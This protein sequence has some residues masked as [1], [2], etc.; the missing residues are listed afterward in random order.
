MSDQCRRG[1]SDMPSPLETMPPAKGEAWRKHEENEARKKFA[2][3][4][5]SRVVDTKPKTL[6]FG[7]F[8]F[9]NAPSV[10]DSRTDLN[11]P[12][13][14]PAEKEAL[15]LQLTGGVAVGVAAV[16]IVEAVAETSN[17]NSEEGEE[18]VTVTAVAVEQGALV[19]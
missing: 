11:G 18:E 17:S 15:T 14:S 3:L 5:K 1:L 6:L 10:I 4:E 19:Q 13:L 9:R 7:S 8:A 16:A 12:S 2:D